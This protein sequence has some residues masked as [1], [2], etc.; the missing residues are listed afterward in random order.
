MR[1]GCRKSDGQRFREAHC[2][3]VVYKA[4]FYVKRPRSDGSAADASLKSYQ[5][6]CF[7][8]ELI[9]YSLLVSS[10]S[11]HNITLFLHIFFLFCGWKRYI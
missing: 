7:S 9:C 11:S 4:R 5:H 6:D 10:C 3:H 8:F 2:E 1:F